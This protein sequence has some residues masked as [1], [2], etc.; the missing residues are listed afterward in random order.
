MTAFIIG[1]KTKNLLYGSRPPLLQRFVIHAHPVLEK[2]CFTPK[3]CCFFQKKQTIPSASSVL[4]AAVS[5][6]TMTLLVTFSAAFIFREYAIFMS[7]KS[8]LFFHACLLNSRGL[9]SF[10]YRRCTILLIELHISF[11]S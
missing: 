5:Y 10:I 1:M 11:H 8:K 2:V 9:F 7:S 6:E 3:C 4:P